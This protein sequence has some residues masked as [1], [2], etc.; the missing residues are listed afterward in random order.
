MTDIRESM[1][2]ELD[3]MHEKIHE[4]VKTNDLNLY[5][6]ERDLAYDVM[7]SITDLM[8]TLNSTIYENDVA[9]G[10]NL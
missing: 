6:I 8:N 10:E 3:R 7:L 2:E 5:G 1:I 9:N 4:W